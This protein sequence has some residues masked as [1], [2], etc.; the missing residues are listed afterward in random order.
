MAEV[1][2][3]GCRLSFVVEGPEDRPA[4][5]LSNSLGSTIELWAPQLAAF[6][7][8]F[9]VI[10]YD[11]RGHGRSKCGSAEYTLDRL[12]RDALAV[13]DAAGVV[14]AHVCGISIGGLTALWLGV[15]ASERV[16]KLVVANTAARIATAE[17]WQERIQTVERHG[18]AALAPATLERWFSAEHRARHPDQVERF[19]S[20]LAECPSE[21]YR[22]C[23]AALRDADLREAIRHIRA[24]TL[25]VVG[26]R[27]PATPPAEGEQI[28]QRIPGARLVALDAAH[29]SSVEQ[30]AAFSAAALEFLGH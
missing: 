13:L 10:R 26:T 12:G 25:V 27:D 22:G 20:M 1:E 6:R 16:N 11:L 5:L 8:S 15:F 29:L 17:L 23:C 7:E 18:V 30:P 9:R 21:G 14:R 24:P 3:D 4:L 19:R 2:A 28:R